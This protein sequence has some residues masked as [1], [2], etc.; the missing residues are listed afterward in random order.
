MIRTAVVLLLNTPIAIS[1]AIREEITAASVSPGIAT[2]SIPT[3]Q[4]DVHGLQFFQCE[5]PGFDRRDHS[6]RLR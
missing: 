4:T 6:P 5:N 2:I 1:S 3:E